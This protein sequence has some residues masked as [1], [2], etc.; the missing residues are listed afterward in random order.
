M[1]LG[2]VN[3]YSNLDFGEFPQDG[4]FADIKVTIDNLYFRDYGTIAHRCCFINA[5]LFYQ[6]IDY[7][8]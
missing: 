6:D 3:D 2:N 4:S 5:I 1:V 7:A 8:L